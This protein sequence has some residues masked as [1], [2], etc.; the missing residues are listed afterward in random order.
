[1]SRNEPVA[2]KQNPANNLLRFFSSFSSSSSSSFF[3]LHSKYAQT[4]PLSTVIVF[5]ARSHTKDARETRKVT[6][7]ERGRERKSALVICARSRERRK[8]TNKN[9]FRWESRGKKGCVS[10]VSRNNVWQC[11]KVFYRH[12]LVFGVDVSG[13]TNGLVITLPIFSFIIAMRLLLL[14]LLGY[15]TQP[16]EIF[17]RIE[18][19]RFTDLFSPRMLPSSMWMCVFDGTR[20]RSQNEIY[21]HRTFVLESQF[22]LHIPRRRYDEAVVIAFRRKKK[23]EKKT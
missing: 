13:E 20:A 2:H 5:R 21:V 10:P 22:L 4:W 17:F 3:R 18:L 19:F 16:D 23:K 14:L 1:M 9:I 8:K 6:A 7:G 12:F 15:A 11:T